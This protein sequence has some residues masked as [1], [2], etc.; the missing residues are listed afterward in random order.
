MKEINYESTISKLE[1]QC[2]PDSF[3]SERSVKETLCRSDVLYGMEYGK[4]KSPAGYFIGAAANGEAELY[5]IA[6]LPQYR[7]KG[8]G[9]HLLE[10]F[11][12]SCPKNTNKVFLEVRSKNTAALELYK[13]Y[14]FKT[15][16]VRKGYYRDDDGVVMKADI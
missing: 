6:V 7:R 13:K 12:D 10:A 5:R 8:M 14:G 11:L 16:H 15:I 1:Q 3:W 2:F 4:D 9:K